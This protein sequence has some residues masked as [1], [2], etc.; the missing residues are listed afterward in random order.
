M[1]KPD[2][3]GN[4][5]P[6]TEGICSTYICTREIGDKVQMTGPFGKAMLMP[7]DDETHLIMVATGTGV[8]PFRGFLRNRQRKKVSINSSLYLGGRDLSQMPYKHYLED[9]AKSD[10]TFDL[11]FCLSRPENP[12]IPKE[13]VQHR[14]TNEADKILS[15][16]EKGSHLYLCGL[17]GMKD[18]IMEALKNSIESRGGDF[19]KM[20][21]QWKKEKRIHIEVY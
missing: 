3:N 8:A 15:Q 20:L 9:L 6:G 12:S 14:I 7:E 13:Y 2:I 11:E 17:K 4:A 21:A 10:K 5:I 18:P 16:M 19:K 1:F